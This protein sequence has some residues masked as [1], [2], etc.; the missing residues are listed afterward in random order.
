MEFLLKNKKWFIV[1][2]SALMAVCLS[3]AVIVGVLS[4][5][6]DKLPYQAVTWT[7]SQHETDYCSPS[8]VSIASGNIYVSDETKGTVMKAGSTTT[9]TAGDQVNGVY[10]YGSNVYALVGGLNAYVVK[11]DANLKEV[12]RA[13]TGHTPV[14]AVMVNGKLYVANRF[15]NTVTVYDA[16]MKLVETV[17]VTREPMALAVSDG[18]I[19]VACHLPAGAANADVVSADVCVINASTNKMTQ[20]ISLINGTSSVKDICVSSDGDYLYVT[21]IFSRYMYPTT[22]LDRG[23]V[24]ANGITVISLKDGTKIG[25]KYDMAGVTLDETNKGAPNPYGITVADGK[26]LVAISGLSQVMAVDETKM[27]NRLG[28]RK[29]AGTLDKVVN[30]IPFLSEARQRIYLDDDARGSRYLVADANEEY[31]YI[32]NYFSGTLTKLDLSD[33]TST[34]ITLAK[35]AAAD[36]VRLGEMLWYDATACYQAWESCAS[37]HPDARVDAFNW[38]NLN[39]GLGNAKQTK[40]MVYSHRTPP[41]MVTGARDSAELAV[42]KGMQFIQMNN[43]QQEELETIN[44]FLRS[45]KP[46]PSPYLN[47]DGSLT[48]S[49]K[50]G[51]KLFAENSCTTCHYGPNFTDTS[52]HSSKTLELD[53]TWETRDFVTPTLVEVWRSAP[54]FFN[55]SKATMEEAVKFYLP[56]APAKDVTDISNYILSIGDSGEPYGVEQVFFTKGDNTV[57]NKL[58]PNQAMGTVT[59]RKQADYDGDVTVKIAYYDKKGE[60]LTEG[61]KAILRNMQVGD[62]ATIK[63]NAFQVPATMEEGGYYKISIVNA[64]GKTITTDYKVYIKEA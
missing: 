54:Y 32:A 37:C 1:G 3:V 61:K 36:N 59:V 40:S 51:K 8:N 41:V 12:A 47:R 17:K 30:E 56:N 10:A 4:V 38:D 19:Y 13:E 57:I 24:N 11:L 44:D 9:F 39:D 53:D 29:D 52:F 55:G 22:Q 43:M 49:A 7:A 6:S 25:D 48:D 63:L 50:R 2:L 58:M 34:K 42:Q 23:W 21:N 28:A 60:M 31:A 15:A 35:S 33:Y 14:D 5:D 18:N 62:V 27:L 26:I 20:A 45:I 46:M 64:K 16:N